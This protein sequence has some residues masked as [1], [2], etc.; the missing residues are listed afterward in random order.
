MHWLF[1]DQLGPHFLTPGEEGPGPETPLLMI[2]ARSVFRR[3]RFH[4][5]KAH[6][7][8]SAMRHRAAEPGDRV[9]YVRADTYRQGLARTARGRPVGVHHPTSHAALRLVRALPQ[10]TVGPARGFLVPM[11]GF[12]AWAEGH[13]GKRLRQ[14]DFYRW[15]RRGHGL[16]MD[17]EQPAAGR[18]NL[19]HDNREPPPREAASSRSAARTGPART[20]STKRSATT[21]TA[22]NATGTFPSSDGTVPACSP[23]P[24][25]R[26]CGHCDAL[27]NT[28]SPP[29]DRTRTPCSPPTPS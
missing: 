4:R 5:A 22:G 16:L 23:P 1:G 10:V 20:T 26:G 12:A 7:V 9:T 11:T 3:R 17:G 27:S 2:E 18:W 24:G 14:E 25:R 29:S 21:S 6:L 28:G 15:V 19:D 8:L 13:G